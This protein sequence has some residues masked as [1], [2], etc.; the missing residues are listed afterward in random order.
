LSVKS[1]AL[2]LPTVRD[3]TLEDSSQELWK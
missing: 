3:W 2:S 1:E